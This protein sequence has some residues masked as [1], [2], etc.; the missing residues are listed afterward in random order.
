M[1]N[2]KK[3]LVFLVDDDSIFLKVLETQFKEQTPYEIKTF[4][5]GEECLKY[6]PS[7]PDLIF[8]D[9]NL[10]TAESKAH[11]GLYILEEIKAR[12]PKVEVIML[13]S[14]DRMDVAVNCM[15][16]H[17]FDYIVKSEAAFVRAQKSISTF[18]YQ[19]EL[20]EKV[21]KYKT[22]SIVAISMIALIILGTI[23]AEI[24]FPKVM[25]K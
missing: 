23:V 2:N 19:K 8:L 3:T 17:A 18:F 5:T 1:K 9:Y 25:N 24:C 15:K 11:N 7:N 16:K 13:S 20:E 12:S 22:S 6:L 10:D 14:Q 21:T 4:S